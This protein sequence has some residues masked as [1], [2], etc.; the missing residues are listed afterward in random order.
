MSLPLIIIAL[1]AI[2]GIIYLSFF[3]KKKRNDKE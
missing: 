2:I 3:Y 1:V